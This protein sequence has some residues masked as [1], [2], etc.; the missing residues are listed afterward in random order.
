MA[1]PWWSVVTEVDVAATLQPSESLDPLG[2]SN[3]KLTERAAA[4]ATGMVES[5]L[6]RKIIA[7]KHLE[8]PY[9]ETFIVR[10]FP[11]L[12]VLS[13]GTL[14][15]EYEVKADDL[16]TAVEYIGGYRRPDQSLT[17]LQAFT[18]EMTVEPPEVPPLISETT[19]ILASLYL[20][21]TLRGTWT[22]EEAIT[23][24]GTFT[25]RS[26]ASREIMK[27]LQMIDSERVL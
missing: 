16:E 19:A 9:A 1:V 7:R 12:E 21:H 25:V 8:M 20:K 18:P 11:V 22:H 26:R 6:G 15:N 2:P 14:L 10:H 3:V 23:Q 13:G 24:I 4:W 5:Y 17:D 27:I